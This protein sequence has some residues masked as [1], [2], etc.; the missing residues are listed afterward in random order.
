M[1]L[2][3]KKENRSTSA[4]TKVISRDYLS[5]TIEHNHIVK[6]LLLFFAIFSGIASWIK[7]CMEMEDPIFLQKALSCSFIIV[8]IICIRK[9]ADLELV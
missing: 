4:T 1:E 8:T 9:A 3:T 5:K 2:N 6:E 7:C